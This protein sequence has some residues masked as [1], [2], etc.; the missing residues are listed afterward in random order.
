MTLARDEHKK[1][2]LLGDRKVIDDITGE[3]T[4]SSKVVKDHRGFVML[5]ENW[6]KKYPDQ[7]INY[8]GV[9]KAPQY[10]ANIDYDNLPTLPEA[11][12]VWNN[13][14]KEWE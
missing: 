1:S 13:E 2:S 5:P 11:L 14:T 8:R 7:K 6:D 12:K 10:I 4:Y 3:A 9:Q